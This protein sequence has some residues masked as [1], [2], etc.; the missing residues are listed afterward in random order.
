MACRPGIESPVSTGFL[1]NGVLRLEHGAAIVTNSIDAIVIS[2]AAI[3]VGAIYS[4]TATDMGVQVCI[5]ALQ[6][7]NYSLKPFAGRLR[8]LQA[9]QAQVRLCGGRNH[10]RR[11]DYRHHAQGEAGRTGSPRARATTRDPTFKREDSC[12]SQC[13][14]HA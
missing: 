3:S 5:I 12:G 1:F 4:S 10:L 7:P 14:W 9:N 11:E 2:L 6:R 8:P 13:S